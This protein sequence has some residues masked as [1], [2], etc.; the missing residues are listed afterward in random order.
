MSSTTTTTKTKNILILGAGISGLQTALSLLT[1][2]SGNN[3]NNQPPQYKITLLAKYLPGDKN[4]NYCSPWA[5]ADWRSHASKPSLAAGDEEADKDRRLRKWEEKTYRTWKSLI[6][7]D[8]NGGKGKGKE[9]G[10]AITPSIYYLGST[11]HGAEIDESGVWFEDVVGG[12]REL[13]VLK[14]EN[15]LEGILGVGVRKAVQFDTVCVDVDVYLGYLVRR[16]EALGG[17][18]TRGEIGTEEG[19][20]GVVRGCRDVLGEEGL[21]VLVNCAGLSA[22]K[23]VEEREA[24]KLF[25]IRGQ[26]LLVQGEAKICKTFVGDLGE[27]GDELLY[28]IPRPGSGKSVVGGVKEANTWNSTPDH[29]LSQ[30]IIHRLKDIG[31]AEDLKNSNGDI[32]V[33]DTYVGFRPGRKGGARV[34]IEGMGERDIGREKGK[35]KKI[36]GVYV[37]HNYG[38]ASGG[39]QSSIGCAE[40]VVELV[41]GLE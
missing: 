30:R 14:P 3:E 28:V 40:E 35:A 29:E 8:G 23:F 17:R 33:L 34:E 16:V 36:E 25:P 7:G 37:V 5:G 2:S 13:D 1:S 31:W 18:I 4:E 26:V 15:R 21:D 10:M 11:Y 6:G 12:Y 32:E 9:M 19:L 24:E 41:R 39:Y 27:K 22:A 20:K 38:H